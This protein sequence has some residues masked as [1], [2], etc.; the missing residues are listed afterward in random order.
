MEKIAVLVLAAGKSSRM[1]SIKQL[2]KI[3]NKTLLDITLQKAKKLYSSTVYCV[4]GANADKIKAEINTSN[5]HFINNQNFEKGLS[6][7]IVSGINYFKENKLNLD[8]V[9]VLLADQPAIEIVYLKTMINLFKQNPS[10]IIAS[11]YDTNFGVPVIFPKIFF[12]NLLL[13]EADKG[14]KEFI[15]NHKNDV[16]CPTRKTIFFDIDTKEDLSLFKKQF[17]NG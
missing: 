6:S 16:I 17:L 8:G 4:L 10:K 5:I 2:E 14:A 15:N 3:E 9:L 1:K 13:I 12:N 7:S 11:N